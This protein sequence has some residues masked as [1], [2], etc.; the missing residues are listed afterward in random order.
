MLVL[1][2]RE[3]ER[4]NERREVTRSVD[5]SNCSTARIKHASISCLC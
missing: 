5:I 1:T 4:K 2:K 3:K